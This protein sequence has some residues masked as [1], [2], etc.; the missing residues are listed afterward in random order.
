MRRLQEEISKLSREKGKAEKDCEER[1]RIME[2]KT[3]QVSTLR[4]EM[5]SMQMEKV[6][7]QKELETMGKE[8]ESLTREK[9]L[10]R[11][12]LEAKE[13]AGEE[14]VRRIE[15]KVEQVRVLGKEIEGLQ[16]ENAVIRRELSEKN[17]DEARNTEH[18]MV[19]ILTLR[20]EVES[21]QREKDTI[22]KELDTREKERESLSAEKVLLRGELDVKEK[23]GEEAARRIEEKVEE[24][25]ALGKEIEGLQMENAVIRREL[26]EKN[27]EVWNAEQKMG[28]ISTLR[29]QVESLQKEKDT[30]W[31]ELETRTKE[32]ES[33][34]SEKALIR[35][36]LE[37]KE[38]DCCEA[39]RSVEQSSEQ[40]TMLGKQVEGLLTEIAVVRTEILEK[41]EREAES[42]RSMERMADQLRVKER[43]VERLTQERTRDQSNLDR[44]KALEAKFHQNL[45]N[46]EMENTTLRTENYKLQEEVNEYRTGDLG[47]GD[48]GLEAEYKRVCQ[49][50]VMQQERSFQLSRDLV[51]QQEENALLRRQVKPCEEKDVLEV[52]KD[53]RR[54]TGMNW[55]KLLVDHVSAVENLRAERDQMRRDM[56]K[57]EEKMEGMDRDIGTCMLEL[58]EDVRFVQGLVDNMDT[59][60]VDLKEEGGKPGFQKLEFGRGTKGGV[61]KERSDTDSGSRGVE[62]IPVGRRTRQ[63]TVVISRLNT[64]VDLVGI[65][66]EARRQI[67]LGSYGIYEPRI[68]Y[69]RKGDVLMDVTERKDCRVKD[70]MERLRHLGSGIRVSVLQPIGRCKVVAIGRKTDRVLI[71]EGLVKVGRCQAEEVELGQFLSTKSG[72]ITAD[73]RAPKDAIRRICDR[74]RIVVGRR[75]LYISEMVKENSRCSRCL[76]MGHWS[77]ECP[78]DTDKSDRCFCCGERGHRIRDCQHRIG[79]QTTVMG[80]ETGNSEKET[81]YKFTGMEAEIGKEAGSNRSKEQAIGVVDMKVHEDGSVRDE[82]KERMESEEGRE[83]TTEGRDNRNLEAEDTSRGQRQRDSLVEGTLWEGHPPRSDIS[84]PGGGVRMKGGTP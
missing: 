60:G 25:R 6:L 46:L 52:E 56:R 75:C 65:L 61:S 24:V 27:D 10:I 76:E 43:E 40:V 34:L 23:A 57:L 77:R 21:L 72:S 62:R 36:E 70:F 83:T 59:T 78:S 50:V 44:D 2:H 19:E 80:K 47:K 63:T 33:L 15:E 37:G 84:A 13:K 7:V 55:K 39:V 38:K 28:E 48:E 9:I 18:R 26:V 16:T 35:G 31:K 79:N 32:M 30:I 41:R 64:G 20:K 69:S 17:D 71:C 22:R 14:T 81:G 3:G 54:V 42:E 67:D 74:G 49:E 73:V 68:K 11:E 66:R 1:A 29:M 53:S 8:V 45:A 4:K 82:R 58:Q 12:D 5:E 51:V